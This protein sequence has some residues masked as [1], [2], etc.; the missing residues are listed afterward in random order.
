MQ[1]VSRRPNRRRH[2]SAQRA[3]ERIGAGVRTSRQSDESPD[4]LSMRARLP[5]RDEHSVGGEHA[6]AHGIQ[7]VGRHGGALATHDGTQ[8]VEQSSLGVERFGQ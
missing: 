1:L 4:R 7:I 8:P 5:Q 6:V 3:V 2:A